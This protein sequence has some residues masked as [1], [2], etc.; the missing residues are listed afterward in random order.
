M[1]LFTLPASALPED[2]SSLLFV[3]WVQSLAEAQFGLQQHGGGPTAD[4]SAVYNFG[5]PTGASFSLKRSPNGDW[6]LGT[7]QQIAEGDIA[8]IIEM[9]KEKLAAGDFGGDVIYQASMHVRAFTITQVMMSNFMRM[10]GD[11]VPIAGMRRLGSRVLLEFTPTPPENPQVPQLFTPETD[12]KVTIFTPGPTAS[13]LTQKTA[14]GMLELVAAICALALG[15]VVEPPLGIFPTNP[16]DATAA[17]VLRFDTSILNLARDGISLD[18]F[19]EFTALGGADGLLRVRGALL[20]YHAALQQ[21]SPDVALMLLVSSLE[22]LIVPRASWRKD[23]ATKR[24]ID[25]IGKLCPE[26]VDS[27]VHHANVEQ[28]FDYRRKEGRQLAAASCSIRSTNFDPLQLIQVSVCQVLACCLYWQ[29][30]EPCGSHC[31]PIWRV[32]PCLHFCKPH[33]HRSSATRYLIRSNRKHKQGAA[34][35]DEVAEVQRLS[36]NLSDNRHEHWRT[37]AYT[38]VPGSAGQHQV[39]AGSFRQRRCLG[40]KE[41]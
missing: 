25:G 37:S 14:S 10:L 15:R 26:V 36:D 29:S 17:Q 38:C 33:G 23:K 21:S 5:D 7:A 31:C 6:N 22:A 20:S 39:F 18:V 3:A 30:R 12:I 19:D 41:S 32:A 8:A 4:S 1:K 2:V 28:A 11:Q 16:E 35:T 27:L 9:A 24:F 40:V 13:D 34:E